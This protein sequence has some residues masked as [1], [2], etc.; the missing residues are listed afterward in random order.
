[1]E[2]YDSVSVEHT[3]RPH[4]PPVGSPESRPEGRDGGRSGPS[5]EQKPKSDLHQRE[6]RDFMK[7]ER[8]DVVY[9]QAHPE[10]LPHTL[11]STGSSVYLALHCGQ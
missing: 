9:D 6:D 8:T 11:H 2:T 7:T 1:M 5:E 4:T 3:S 10:D